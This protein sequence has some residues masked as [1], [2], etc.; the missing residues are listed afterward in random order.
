MTELLV[1]TFSDKSGKI[2]PRAENIGNGQ[3]LKHGTIVA[4]E[5]EAATLRFIKRSTSIPVPDVLK[6]WESGEEDTSHGKQRGRLLM[7]EIPG[8]ALNDAWPRMNEQARS[9][10][11]IELQKHLKE[12]RS[13]PQIERKQGWIALASDGI[14]GVCDDSISDNRDPIGPFET[15]QLFNEYLLRNIERFVPHVAPGFRARLQ[16]NHGVSFSHADLDPSHIIVDTETGNIIGIIDWE[17]AG[18]WPDYWEYRKARTGKRHAD[19]WV[20][21]VGGAMDSYDDEWRLIDDI[22][23]F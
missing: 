2:K 8:E 4:V 10:V 15:E 6:T 13:L 17:M 9:T 5:R 22:A 1:G 7:S 11:I 14:N 23:C 19:W 21:L 18:W 12:L 20:E 16:A 3:Y